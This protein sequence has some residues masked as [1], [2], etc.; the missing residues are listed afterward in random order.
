MQVYPTIIV[1]DS[2]DKKRRKLF[3]NKDDDNKKPTEKLQ[4]SREVLFR[5]AVHVD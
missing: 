5:L 2:D 4:D 3:N 1:D